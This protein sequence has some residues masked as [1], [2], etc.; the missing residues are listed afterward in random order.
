M[1]GGR[2]TFDEAWELYTGADFH[3]LGRMAHAVRLEKHPQP[4]VTYVV[5]RNINYSNICS[6]GCRFCEVP[7][8]TTF[9]DLGMS[10]LCA[11]YVPEERLG[12]MQP[13]PYKQGQF[14]PGTHLPIKHPEVRVNVIH[15]GV[16]AIS[17]GDVSLAAVSNALVVG[18]NVRPSAEARALAEREGVEIRTYRVIYQLTEDIEQA[19]VGMLRPVTTE[20]TIGEVEVRQTFRASRIGVIAGS[21]V[22][23]GHITRGA[24]VR[25]VRRQHFEAGDGVADLAQRQA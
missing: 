11:S 4:V 3:D 24:K 25:L 20:E 10:P 15:T 17:E 13:F 5:D 14:L 16:G 21:Y 23:E 9:V 12:A 7:L 22:R 1:S 19:L 2:L 18:F 6:C 8:R